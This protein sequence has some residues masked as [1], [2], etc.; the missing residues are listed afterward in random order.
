MAQMLEVSEL[1]MRFGGL[2]ALDSVSFS[3]A[4]RSI[5]GLIGPNGSGKTTMFNV[6]NGIYKPSSGHIAFK[7]EE[8]TGLE[9]WMIAK[10][11]IARTFQLMRV[12]N[13]M[14]VTENLMLGLSV[15]DNTTLAE[16]LLRLSRGRGL[17]SDMRDKAREMLKLIGLEKKAKAPAEALSIGQRRMLQLGQAAISSPKLIMLDEPAAGLDPLNLDRLVDLILYFRDSMGATVMLI[18]HIM[19]V[20]MRVSDMITVMDYGAKIAEGP[21]AAVKEDP[22]VIEAYL[23]SGA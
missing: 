21:P 9:P 23:G 19:S 10:K 5:H 6:I 8:I 13:G 4:E 16:T 20:V 2:T 22:R 15:R 17:E 18:E 14:T 7:G 1:T 11:G 12:F 3:V